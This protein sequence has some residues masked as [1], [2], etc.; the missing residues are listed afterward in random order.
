M[1]TEQKTGSELAALRIKQNKRRIWKENEKIRKSME[2]KST[3]DDKLLGQLKAA[4]SNARNVN[5][6]EQV[7]IK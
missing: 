7:Q 1:T 2:S 4:E 6:R 3:N 5:L